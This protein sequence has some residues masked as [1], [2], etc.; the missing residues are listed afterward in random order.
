MTFYIDSKK[1]DSP[2][3]ISALLKKCI[4]CHPEKWTEIVFLCVGTDRTTGDCLGPYI[5][6]QLL[7]HAVHGDLR[8]RHPVSAGPCSESAEAPAT[9]YAAVI[10]KRL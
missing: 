1:A 3:R 10:R 6:Q 2:R 5:G 8:L 7:S 9:I 4:L